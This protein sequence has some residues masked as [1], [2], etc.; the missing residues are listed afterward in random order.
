MSRYL[1]RLGLGLLALIPFM[2]CMGAFTDLG[3][4]QSLATYA[5]VGFYAG[6]TSVIDRE[7]A[8]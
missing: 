6:C 3:F 1:L 8:T 4:W 2:V 7:V 5:A